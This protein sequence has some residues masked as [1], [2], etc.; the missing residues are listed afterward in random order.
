MLIKKSTE[1]LRL[2]F[3]FESY[4]DWLENWS[5]S[6]WLKRVAAW[7]K[8]TIASFK[9]VAAF[10]NVRQYDEICIIYFIFMLILFLPCLFCCYSLFQCAY[11]SSTLFLYFCRS[12]Y[13]Y[14]LSLCQ[15]I[16]NCCLGLTQ[17]VRSE[18]NCLAKSF[19]EISTHEIVFSN[20]SDLSQIY[21]RF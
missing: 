14:V 10:S 21:R 18:H 20:V 15:Y 6:L 17:D 5:K 3:H 16:H 13:L 9:C 1:V 4:R 11:I 2:K 7:F 8:L 19:R 12:A